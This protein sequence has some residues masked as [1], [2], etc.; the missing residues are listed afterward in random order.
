MKIHK[1]L[2]LKDNS[3]KVNFN[4]YDKYLMFRDFNIS[5]IKKDQKIN[6]FMYLIHSIQGS[7]ITLNNSFQYSIANTFDEIDTPPTYCSL[8]FDNKYNKKKYLLIPI[9]DFYFYQSEY[10]N[11]FIRLTEQKYLLTF[12]KKYQ[13][14]DEIKKLMEFFEKYPYSHFSPTDLRNFDYLLYRNIVNSF[15]NTYHKNK[16][17]NKNAEILLYCTKYILFDY[18]EYFNKFYNRELN[19]EKLYKKLNIASLK[20]K[21]IFI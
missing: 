4:L 5:T 3:L 13:K 16:L 8:D 9:N 11:D 12:L 21:D 10:I 17:I 6:E 1:D 14:N 7:Y 18:E 20:Y 2:V 19:Y 15:I